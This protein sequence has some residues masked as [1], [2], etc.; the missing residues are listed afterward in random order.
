MADAWF[1]LGVV[2][3]AANRQQEAIDVYRRLLM[4]QPDHVDACHNL[5][6][7][8]E[9]CGQVQEAVALY[10]RALALEPARAATHN[11]LSSA[12]YRCG[13]LEEAIATGRRALALEPDSA[14][15]C[16]NLGCALTAARRLTEAVEV[17]RRAIALRPDF[18]EAWY[19][20]ANALREQGKCAEAAAAC[21]RALA[22][23][24][25]RA[26]AHV[27]L[28][29]ILQ[30][31][32]QFKEA[33]ACYRRA[34]E[35]RPNDV[36][37]Y[38]N[39]GNA[40][41]NSGQLDQAIAAFRTCVSL[42]P[43][44]HVAHCN[45]GN[46]LKD[47]GQI[48]EAI[49][50]YRRAVELCP[51]DV[52]SHSNLAYSVHYHPDYDAGAILAENRRWN[53]VH[54]AGLDGSSSPHDNDP[55]P[56]RR[57]RIGYVGSDFRDHCQA[58]FTIP[59]LSHHDHEQFEV[60]CYA[61]VARPDTFTERL[62]ECA[63]CWRETA[64][65]NDE[66]VARQARTDGIDVLVDLT[67]HMSNGRPLVFARKPAPVQVAY[68]AYPGTT[69]LSAIDYRL[70]DPYLDPPGETDADYV[71]QSVRLPDTFWCY[72]PL[73]DQPSPNSLPASREGRITFGCL[74]NFCKVAD[75]TLA[76]WSRVLREVE[77][78][79]L[80]LLAPPGEHR[81]RVLD[82]FRG[83]N[84]EPAQ[85]EFVEHRPR[86]KY[87]ELYHGIDVTLDT[88]P[89]NGHTTSLDSL[90]MGVPVVTRVGRTVVGRA[91]YSQLSNLGLSELVAWNDD[92]FVSIA[93]EL[94]CDSA[95]PGPPPRHAP[96]PDGAIPADGRRSLHSQHRGGVPPHVAALVPRP[97]SD[98]KQLIGQAA[99]LPLYALSRGA[100]K[101]SHEIGPFGNSQPRDGRRGA[102]ARRSPTALPAAGR[103][104]ITPTSTAPVP[105]RRPALPTAARPRS[106]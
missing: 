92:Q 22:L 86:A 53:V 26:E 77:G 30:A 15:A 100:G 72:D 16:N 21:R 89:Y 70:T 46:A 29:N 5:A 96:R 63:D 73:A 3:Q 79:R 42:R 75:G 66:E 87:L 34:L 38:S 43:E 101:Q 58:L 33:I 62:R 99:S 24:P 12:L 60:F 27:N 55:D 88:L 10:R 84:V 40:L 51:S 91:G 20:L 17:L 59:L 90:W 1:G 52:I 104:F 83:A 97:T 11:N 61:N 68:L 32:R 23:R 103:P 47:A 6:S 65:W 81:L 80:V 54:T 25:D 98:P 82:R 13:R 74:N 106:T 50:C 69:G 18:A 93:S 37:A 105:W 102:L 45:L 41:R 8:L 19:N 57:L 2:L 9:L 28:G 48:D 71:E 35:L 7:A 44:F 39:L 76:L 85:I 56:Q 36:E 31:A 94:A 78:S 49:A 4:M 67:M 14:M 64:G 95:A